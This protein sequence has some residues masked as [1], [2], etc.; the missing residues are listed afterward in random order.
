MIIDARTLSKNEC[1]KTDICIAGAGVAGVAL[2]REFIGEEFR[3]CLLES[4][5]LGPDRATQ[6]LFWGNNVGHPYFPLDTARTCGFGGSSNRWTAPGANSSLGVRL[7]PLDDIDFEEREWIPDSG[8][9]FHKSDLDPFYVR[10]QKTCKIGP[11]TYDP[12]DWED[13]QH[14]PR[15]P[16]LNE[17]VATTIF[18]FGSR[19]AFTNDYRKEIDLA[20]NIMVYTYANVVEIET[21]ENKNTVSRL[22]IAC[23]G[24][25][26]VQVSAKLFVLAMG[27]LE[28]PRL[29]LI[30][31]KRQSTGLGN[32]HDL[33]GRY[34][35]EHP[36]LWSGVFIP[37]NPD[38][39][40]SIGLYRTHRVG[41]LPI[42]GKLTLSKEV[43][44]AE[45]ILNYCVSM[46]PTFLGTRQ[47]LA[48]NLPILSWP[49]QTAQPREPSYIQPHFKKESSKGVESL[50]VLLSSASKEHV[51]EE[52][53]NLLGNVL[54]YI[55]KIGAAGYRKLRAEFSRIARKFNRPTRRLVFEMNHMTEQS[56]NPNSRV[57][58]SD[59]KD[60]F[61]RNRICLDWQLN[62]L[63][64]RSIIR[65][66]QIID[67][68]LRRANLG[69]LRIDLKDETPPSNLEGGWHHMG[70]TRMHKNPK[71]GVVDENCRVHDIRNLF[72]AGPS[73]FPTCGYANPVLTTVALA[74]R[75]ADHIKALMK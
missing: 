71:Q 56:P 11:F 73:V 28:T 65:A 62:P 75:L 74:I 46:H 72:I 29:L 48:P 27:A 21:T 31:N 66:Q 16:F 5:G 33:V 69:K 2:A 55:D 1:I 10:A 17:R 7:R 44:R 15:L 49:L 30:S 34:F 53:G 64:I 63:D 45:K 8:W 26:K 32:Q 43:L 39:L 70:T 25:K 51:P 24:G 60:P 18:Q 9:P 58:L 23:L 4:G 19:D 52:P 59:E 12:E 14:T 37:S 13:P 22:Q 38:I 54:F 61:G 68:E 6:S 57:T 41:G 42:M 50:K 3:V 67:E 35:M 47:N 20:H 36:H 40:N